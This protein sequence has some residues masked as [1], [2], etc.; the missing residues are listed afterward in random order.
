[1]ARDLGSDA[2]RLL[3]VTVTG[4]GVTPDR[5]GLCLRHPQ[6]PVVRSRGLSRFLLSV[7]PLWLDVGGPRVSAGRSW[8]C[9]ARTRLLRDLLALNLRIAAEWARV[10]RAICTMPGVTAC[11]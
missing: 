6:T 5:V 7:V 3:C 4:D 2:S 10:L 1:V 11:P 9:E 8:V